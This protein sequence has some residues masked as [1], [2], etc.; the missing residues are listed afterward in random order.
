MENPSPLSLY[1]VFYTI[2]YFTWLNLFQ[3]SAFMLWCP[4]SCL[5][6]SL[7]PW[8]FGGR[9]TCGL[10]VRAT[11]FTTLPI[12]QDIN[13]LM[14]SHVSLHS[15]QILVSTMQWMDISAVKLCKL[16][17]RLGQLRKMKLISAI[18]AMCMLRI[19]YC[20][21]PVVNYRLCDVFPRWSMLGLCS[22]F[23]TKLL[24]NIVVQTL[25]CPK[26]LND[27]VCNVHKHLTL[28]GVWWLQLF[29]KIH[30]F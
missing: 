21:S 25:Y 22:W 5:R 8:C 16:S 6:W 7:L 29:R 17:D 12:W 15:V 26:F 14:Y 9:N 13:N 2:L 30:N 4:E 3:P 19:V 11:T 28:P 27:N 18:Y 1:A 10:P 24:D 23:L 20:V